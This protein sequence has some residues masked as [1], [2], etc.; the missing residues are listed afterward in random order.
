MVIIKEYNFCYY[1]FTILFFKNRQDQTTTMLVGVFEESEYTRR[2][3]TA[4]ACKV[5][6]DLEKHNSVM[7]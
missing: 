1:V 4:A 2:T 7:R 6:V 3:I 5:L